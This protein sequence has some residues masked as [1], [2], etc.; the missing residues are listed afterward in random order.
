MSDQE[1]FSDRLMELT[2]VL[3]SSS[4]ADKQLFGQLFLIANQMAE[5]GFTQDQLQLIVVTGAQCHNNP[6]LKQLFGLLIGDINLESDG[7]YQ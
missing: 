7:D 1:S 2:S 3:Q 5:N 4:E 6:H